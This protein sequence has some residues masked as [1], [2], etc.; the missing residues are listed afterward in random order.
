MAPQPD[1]QT[2][3]AGG[4]APCEP[5]SI[6]RVAVALDPHR[7]GRDAALLGSAIAAAV[8][9][10]PMLLAVE[11]DLPL[12]VPGLER[13]R[14]RRETEAMLREAREAL[15]PGARLKVTADLSTARGLKRLVGRERCDLLTMGSSRRGPEGE[16]MI[17]RLTR[18]LFDQLGC[19]MAIA[20]RGLSDQP[21]LVLRRIGVGFDGG[22]EAQAAL[23]M[24]AA[25]AIGCGAR[26]IVRGVV[27]DRLPA[28]GWPRAWVGS[29]EDSWRE[30]MDG[31]VDALREVIEAT[32]R[33]LDADLEIEV[34]RGRPT[35]SL[36]GLSAEVDLLVIGSRRWGTMARLLLGGTGEALVHGARCSLLVVPRPR[37]RR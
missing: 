35:A 36:L 4:P 31:E 15:V 18:Q 3:Q 14:F 6:N 7:E 8:E 12:I 13:K 19:G 20:P 10:E 17:G 27:D 32:T 23:G 29:F 2:I 9:A 34:R 16:V 33:D 30:V 26:L 1:S 37:H 25:V 21:K 28:L 11:P 24:A 22:P 5:S